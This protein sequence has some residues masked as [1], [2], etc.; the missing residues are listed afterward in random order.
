MNILTKHIK[1]TLFLGVIGYVIIFLAFTDTKN[2]DIKN[3]KLIK[4]EYKTGVPVIHEVIGTLYNPVTAQCDSDPLITAD[5][6]KINL[7]KLAKEEIRWV[8]LSR[9]LLKRWGGP[10]NYGDTLRVHHPHSKVR[11]LW[12]VH[13][14]MNRRFRKR[15]D[16]LVHSNTKFPGKCPHIL[17]SNTNYYVSRE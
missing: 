5:N 8:A 2:T 10:Y 17:I 11:G 9:D 7:T 16:F 14:T 1:T 12:V 13:D 15:I 6:S 3:T 4:V